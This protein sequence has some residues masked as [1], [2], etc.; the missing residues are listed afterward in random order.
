[1]STYQDNQQLAQFVYDQQN[2]IHVG[3]ET[4][5]IV[6]DLA[7]TKEPSSGYYGAVYTNGK[8][9]YILASR[10][11]Q[12]FTNKIHDAG[13]SAFNQ[14]PPEF[15]DAYQLAAQA[16][17][18]VK[19]HGGTLSFDGHSLGGT[20]SQLLAVIFGGE[21]TTFNPYNSRNFLD[22]V[23]RVDQSMVNSLINRKNELQQQVDNG[24]LGSQSY[25]DLVNQQLIRIEANNKLY[26]AWNGA[27][28]YDI[29]NYV[30]ENDPV[31]GAG[32]IQKDQ[33]GETVTIT[34]E[35]K[36]DAKLMG[37]NEYLTQPGALLDFFADIDTFHSAS[38]FLLENLT[39]SSGNLQIKSSKASNTDALLELAA[40]FKDKKSFEIDQ[41][42]AGSIKVGQEHE[43]F[44]G[45]VGQTSDWSLTGNTRSQLITSQGDSIYTKVNLAAV[46]TA[47]EIAAKRQQAI[48]FM[49]NQKY[50]DGSN[51][52]EIRHN[53]VHTDK[54]SYLL[55]AQIEPKKKHQQY[56]PLAF[57]L[58][59]SGK[60]ETVGLSAGI[61][62][63]HDADG[64]KTGTGWVAAGDG[65]VVRDIN[66]N[67]QIDS[68]RE[69]FGDNTILANGQ[70]A[71]DAFEAIADLDVNK[72]GKVD[73]KDATFSQLKVW[74][75][76]NQN[77]ISEASELKTLT[78]LGITSISTQASITGVQNSASGN[79]EIGFSSFERADGSKGSSGAFNFV[80][81]PVN[82]EFI[83]T[84]DTSLVMDIPNTSGS[85]KVRDLREAAALSV[86]LAS[87]VRS[88]MS[89]NYP[90]E[91]DIETVVKL[92]AQTGQM[93]T[94]AS[95]L[96][97]G[98]HPAGAR[99]TNL[100]TNEINKLGVL[101]KF[102]GLYAAMTNFIDPMDVQD[103][104]VDGRY[105]E[106]HYGINIDANSINNSYKSLNIEVEKDLALA[107][108]KT[109]V[110][111]LVDYKLQD[112]KVT[113]DLSRIIEWIQ[114]ETNHEYAI[115]QLFRLVNDFNSTGNALFT[116]NVSQQTSHQ[117]IDL[118]FDDNSSLLSGANVENAMIKLS[119]VMNLYGDLQKN[120]LIV[121][122]FD[123]NKIHS[124]ILGIIEKY[125]LTDSDELSKI[126]LLSNDK[127]LQVEMYE[128]IAKK[129]PN[130]VD[131]NKYISSISSSKYGT[132]ISDNLNGSI[133]NDYM[134]SL[135]GN[136]TIYG[137]NGNDLL[138]GDA[139]NDIIDGGLGDDIVYGGSGND[140]IKAGGGF[141][142]L[143]GGDGN[144]TLDSILVPTGYQSLARSTVFV[145]GA[146]DDYLI[147][148]L[149]SDIYR[150]GRGDGHDV[151]ND[152]D[153]PD[154][155]S[156]SQYSSKYGN[157]TDVIEFGVGI[158]KEDLSFSK[159]GSDLIINIG[160]DGADSI[161]IKNGYVN[162]RNYIERF[163]FADG[164]N[165]NVLNVVTSS[166]GNDASETLFGFDSND[167][168]TAK[169]GDDV[170]YAQGG[171]DNISGGEGNDSIYGQGG[172]DI[173]LGDTGNDVIDGGLGDD[174]VYGGS[175]NDSIKAGGGFDVLYGGDGNDTIDSTL[176][177][178][179]YQSLA[180]STVFVGGAGDDVVYAQGGNDSISGGEGN[181]TIYGQNGNDLLFGDSGNDVIDG[182]SGDD[183]V[184]GGSGN[185]SIKAGGGFDVLNGGDGNDSLDSS[186]VPT[187]Y[188]SLSRSTVFI[189]GAGDDYLVG[190]LASDIYRFG[191]GDGHDMIDDYDDPDTG[192]YSQ[193]SSKYGNLTDVIEFGTGITK[194]DLSFSK[195]GNDLVINIGTDGADSITIKNGYTNY[196][197]YIELIA[198]A[199]GARLTKDE[200]LKNLSVNLTGT[201]SADI[202][203]S[204]GGNDTITAKGGNDIIT[205]GGGRDTIDAGSGDDII[206]AG[207][208][209]DTIAGGSGNDS[210]I[211]KA[212]DGQDIIRDIAGTD[213]LRLQAIQASE[214]KFT[215]DN[216]DLLINFTNTNKDSIRVSEW[217]SSADNRIEQLKLD[218]GSILDLHAAVEAQLITKYGTS[219]DD[220]LELT[221]AKT[222][223][224]A[225]TGNDTIVDTSANNTTYI[226]NKG[227]GKDTIIESNSSTDT[228]QLNNITPQE[229]SYSKLD[230]D[231]IIKLGSDEQITIKD[232]TNRAN[233]IENI[234]FNNGMTL[235]LA[236]V[237]ATAKIFG[238]DKTVTS[239]T[240]DNLWL[241]QGAKI[242][243]RE[244]NNQAY[245]NSNAIATTV[246]SGAGNDN[247]EVYDNA[248]VTLNL[249]NGNNSALVQD[250]KHVITTGTGNDNV[251]LG[252]G[253]ASSINVGDGDDNVTITKTQ[254]NSSFSVSLGAGNDS[255][256][257]NGAGGAIKVS[258]LSGN[259]SINLLNINTQ[260]SAS[261]GNNL[262]N[263]DNSG[264]TGDVNSISLAAGDDQLT[265]NS[266]G[267]TTIRVGEGA[268]QIN[269]DGGGSFS[270]SAGGGDDQVKIQGLINSTLNLA[271]GNNTI[272]AQD[273]NHKITT[274]SGNDNITIGAGTSTISSGD[275][276]DNVTI[277]T[278]QNTN[279]YTI[280]LGA[281]NDSVQ[282]N[283]NGGELARVS[284]SSGNDQ[285][286]I[287]N[288]R[289]QITLSSGDN[290]VNLNNS[291]LSGDNNSISTGAGND[292]IAVKSNGSNTIN[293]GNGTNQ[294]TLSGNSSNTVTSGSG[295][296]VIKSYAGSLTLNSG[297]GDDVLEITSNEAQDKLT[298]NLGD[299]N[300]TVKITATGAAT[301]IANNYGDDSYD[302]TGTQVK[303]SDT[304]GNMTL[305]L[306]NQQL[307]NDM[308]TITTGTGNDNISISSNGSNTIN[309]GNGNNQ[310][311]LS[312]NSK[313]NITSGS[314]D[315][316][317]L[318]GAGD[319]IINA[320][321]GNDI[322]VGGTGNDVLNGS[323]GN[324]SYIFN[325]GD[326]A[327]II[328]D[329]SGND[330]MKLGEGIKKEDLWFKKEGKDLSINNL[331]NQD[332]MTVKNWYSGSTNKIEQIEL[333]DGKH[334]SN[335]SIDLLV[336]AMATFD[337]KPMAETNFTAAQKDTL[338]NALANT[339]V[340]PTK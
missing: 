126:V 49:L 76:K 115:N 279:N 283:G 5:T 11:T 154:S 178:T 243:L 334:I 56:D 41:T 263:L 249:G 81:N 90:N 45:T 313:D 289:S 330:V 188:Q 147:G 290:T 223:V 86:D 181:D 129:T 299:G 307:T 219:S 73:A 214:L 164:N 304:L 16:T 339:W 233:R 261:G 29:T 100:T 53:E 292:T 55:F 167:V 10:G 253:I 20:I 65:L 207:T 35:A 309:A 266:S 28:Q 144:D 294:I 82:S 128:S 74:N 148:W 245:I 119:A 162:V 230:N 302:L 242:N 40:F 213:A 109:S 110:F 196:R 239:N 252:A 130:V 281:G 138:F 166:L 78:E 282:L 259:D 102:T 218:D 337:V 142:V 221:G 198:F 185:D 1:M 216:N 43:L 121:S 199:D 33:L 4:W 231:L 125:S 183:I 201:D 287:N 278:T 136:D 51:M 42:G 316:V 98:E 133:L 47:Q 217:F 37:A 120:S 246:T 116:K 104:K 269:L 301:T 251:T 327:D 149:A 30:I 165:L 176:A 189:G 325:K 118:L 298:L 38:S 192:R 152:Y 271:N 75:D 238:N 13:M 48:D 9:E 224:I 94:I 295:N 191:K 139:G 117:L 71:K 227:D 291:Q 163:V 80:G 140:S 205:S 306:N 107:S 210:Y 312:G 135:L 209:N 305:A 340:D 174:I 52:Y 276:D 247:V 267:Q 286:N 319:D 88:Y 31:S 150:F 96:K 46:G 101:E 256:K 114:A 67:G 332:K 220:I 241:E 17:A 274:G 159:S 277:T 248:N 303:L 103:G 268:N 32:A 62:F 54:Q 280:N 203:T 161:T 50:E 225:G 284:S 23:E 211:Y 328:Q 275:G 193:Y 258:N 208:G 322:I 226:F 134:H 175:G 34:Y 170:V 97:T 124:K 182:G 91:A 157:L 260:I 6:K 58:D 19:A 79:V 123:T 108:G 184:Y 222:Q 169:G 70:K 234:S 215:K 333:A 160:T 92:W 240:D 3:T 293:V 180:R 272:L 57:D 285:I 158:S 89:K 324:D 8:G 66:K 122:S 26:D 273:G 200:Y 61:L 151:I 254:T 228:I 141:D 296:D 106:K 145:G 127:L 153:D 60:V 317:I 14:V 15:T 206:N 2:P 187:G 95:T 22:S 264:L 323:S 99:G 155:G 7:I 338:Q 77:G 250:G 310:I 321:A 21:A 311:I 265:A 69:I 212:G 300:D 64:V 173:L 186:L 288:I 105:T 329:T 326:G 335:I 229:V 177:P 93:D 113:M 236:E 27:S 168:I 87:A 318:A 68:G 39:S 237:L 59:G 146:G 297:A 270:V 308:N 132:E 143:Y 172:N 179:G 44:I 137:Q 194:E 111:N 72:D 202:L 36:G 24:E 84:V 232:F 171:N 63:D 235:L 315:D 314:G 112:G 25:L 320:G 195:S 197:N 83:D 190:S 255:L 262:I 204:A 336:Q 331:T 131:V 156:Y 12:N 18:Y 244:G 85:G 257:V